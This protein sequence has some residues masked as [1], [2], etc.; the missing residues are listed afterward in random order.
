MGLCPR[1]CLGDESPKN[2]LFLV[3]TGNMLV[4]AFLKPASCP[5]L[6]GGFGKGK[7]TTQVLQKRQ[8]RDA[9]TSLGSLNGTGFGIQQDVI[10]V[11]LGDTR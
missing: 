6:A 1:P 4:L 8:R 5:V 9:Y 2:P 7:T 10:V 11:Q 3:G